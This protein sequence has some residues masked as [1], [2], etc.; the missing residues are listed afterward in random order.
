MKKTIFYQLSE[1]EADFIRHCLNYVFHRLARHSKK[2]PMITLRKVN[3]LRKQLE[4][5]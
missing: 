1:K 5:K 2:I 4:G 3:K